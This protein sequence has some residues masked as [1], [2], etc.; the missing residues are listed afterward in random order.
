MDMN[1]KAEWE[2]I[3]FDSTPIYVRPNAPD[4][5]V[6]NQA[7]DDALVKF[8]MQEKNSAEIKNLLK[9]IDG[10]RDGY[11]NSRCEQL[12]L[13]SL[14]ECWFHITNRCNMECRHCMFKSSPHS[15]DELTEADCTGIIHES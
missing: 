12:K 1:I 2:R 6:P 5:F 9:R 8:L 7:A 3:E 13:D 15:H 4:W 11:Y 14:K 10:P